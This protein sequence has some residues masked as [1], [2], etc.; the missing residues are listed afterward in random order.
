MD[1]Y[2][3]FLDPARARLALVRGDLTRLEGLLTELDQWPLSF[4]GHLEGVTTRLDVLVALG[5]REAVEATATRLLQP[6]TYV[7]PFALRAL[8]CVRGDATLIAQ[9]V[10]RFEALGLD[11]HAGQTLAMS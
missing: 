5:R 10:E 3:L 11:W 8:G 2:Q 6:G 7:E 1:G 4:H 9:A